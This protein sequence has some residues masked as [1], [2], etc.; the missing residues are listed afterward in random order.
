[1]LR[2]DEWIR[3]MGQ[4]GEGEGRPSVGSLTK[5]CLQLLFFQKNK[6]TKSTKKP[7]RPGWNN[8]H[9]RG[10]R[11][12]RPTFGGE[13]PRGEAPTGKPSRC[14]CRSCLPALLNFCRGRKWR[15]VSGRTCPT[16]GGLI[17]LRK[18]HQLHS[19]PRRSQPELVPSRT[20]DLPGAGGRLGDG[21]KDEPLTVV[22]KD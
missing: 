20:G 1:M 11:V 15:K 7:A 22:F 18:T 21:G 10:W 6:Q 3:R 17:P 8:A 19:P 13:A 14:Y 9:S 5:A 12:T 16:P 4:F 2:G